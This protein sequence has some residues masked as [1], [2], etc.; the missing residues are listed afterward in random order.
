MNSALEK[1]QQ[2][3]RERRASGEVSIL[4]PVQKAK[5][6]PRSLRA[7]INAKCWDRLPTLPT[8]TLEG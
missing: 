7:A 1:A 3:N 8:E 4:S 6:N 2:V 5:Q